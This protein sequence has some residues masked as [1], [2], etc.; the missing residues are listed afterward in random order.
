MLSW[1]V[2]SKSR[3]QSLIKKKKRGGFEWES[4]P[5]QTEFIFQEFYVKMRALSPYLAY[6]VGMRI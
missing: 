5:K 3:N 4:K 1:V 6:D 2:G